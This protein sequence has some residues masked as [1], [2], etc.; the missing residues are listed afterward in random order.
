MR[1]CLLILLTL[2][3]TCCLQAQQTDSTRSSEKKPSDFLNEKLPDWL[4]LSGEYRSRF[5]YYDGGGFNQAED[6]YLLSRTRFNILFKPTS[7]LS[8][9]AKRRIR[10]LS[11]RT[12]FILPLL[13]RTHGM[14][15]RPILSWATRSGSMLAFTNWAAGN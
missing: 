7:S 1:L 3:C 13:I 2:C 10:A 5:E 15:S 11:S 12:Q 6:G 8:F 9:S 4:Q 14:S